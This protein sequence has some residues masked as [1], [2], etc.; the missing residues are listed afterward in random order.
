MAPT[1]IAVVISRLTS[2]ETSTVP[3]HTSTP[4]LASIS[5]V[6]HAESWLRKLP[7]AIVRASARSPMR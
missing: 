1:G 5:S 2:L 3:V 4:D 6:S 7:S